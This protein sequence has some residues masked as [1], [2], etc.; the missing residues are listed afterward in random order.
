M[1]RF[2]LLLAL[3]FVGAFA[4]ADP[5]TYD[6]WDWDKVHKKVV[7]RKKISKLKSELQPEELGNL[8]G[9]SVC[10]EDQVV[11]RMA[12]VPV[13][14]ICKVLS[15]KV[16]RVIQRARDSGFVFASIVGYRVGRTKGELNRNGLRTQF[17]NHSFGTAIDFNS[18]ENGLYDSCIKWGPKCQLIR[19]GPYQSEAPR[20][21]N[22]QSILY[23]GM[24][25]EGF[26]WG[27]EINGK[28]KDFMHFS[29][30]GL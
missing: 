25:S 14:K 23:Q 19:G 12:R 17:S 11:V 3:V 30:S 20:S 16:K 29:L 4:H 8:P 15:E 9:C 10:Q 27:G 1:T 26:K 2:W 28:Q 7:N 21:I 5:C 22:R 24:M 13:F 6:S 18:E